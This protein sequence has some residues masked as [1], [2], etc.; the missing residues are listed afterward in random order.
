MGL[1]S[2]TMLQPSTYVCLRHAKS[3]S[4]LRQY[5]EGEHEPGAATKP[6]WETDCVRLNP[7]TGE[8]ARHW[9]R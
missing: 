2:Q 8:S 7:G 6:I 3:G 5:Q 1:M 4:S 9:Y